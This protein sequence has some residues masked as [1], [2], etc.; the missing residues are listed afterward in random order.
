VTD[1]TGRPQA[2]GP[3]DPFPDGAEGYHEIRVT[4]SQ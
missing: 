1:T 4:V 3:A 2:V